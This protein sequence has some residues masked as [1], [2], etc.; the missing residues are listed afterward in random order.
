MENQ[1]PLVQMNW[2]G[3]G[4]YIAVVAGDRCSAGKVARAIGFLAGITEADR[5][6]LI[7]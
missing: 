1:A 6:E 5:T 3:A 4:S 2:H 7:S